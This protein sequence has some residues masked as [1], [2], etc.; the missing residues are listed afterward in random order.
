M[1]LTYVV[2]EPHARKTNGLSSGSKRYRARFVFVGQKIGSFSSGGLQPRIALLDCPCG[3]LP[4][5]IHSHLKKQIPGEVQV[6]IPFRF[7]SDRASQRS[8]GSWGSRGSDE[9]NRQ[10]SSLTVLSRAVR[11]TEISTVSFVPASCML[12]KA[13]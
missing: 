10:A 12:R 11:K 8:E 3:E 13:V 9:R 4:K 7:C 1:M 6:A 2:C 5:C